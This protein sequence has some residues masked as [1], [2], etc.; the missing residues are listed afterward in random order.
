M[1]IGIS[2]KGLNPYFSGVIT[3][4]RKNG[5]I[6]MEKTGMMKFRKLRVSVRVIIGIFGNCSG[7]AGSVYS[8]IRKVIDDV[9]NSPNV[10]GRLGEA[11]ALLL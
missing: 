10:K 6:F 3:L 4:I 9:V 8:R 5:R 11:A 2:N 1:S 7:R